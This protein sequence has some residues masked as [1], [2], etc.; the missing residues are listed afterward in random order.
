L[1]SWILILTII[2]SFCG[3]LANAQDHAIDDSKNPQYL[4][5]ITGDT[6]TFEGGKLTFKGV[7]IVTFYSMAAK[8]DV[9]HFLMGTFVEMWEKN[10]SAYKADPPDGTISVLDE[11][12]ALGAVIEVSNPVSTLNSITFKARVLEGKLPPAFNASSFFLKLNVIEAPHTQ[13]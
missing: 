1:K 3:V 11:K 9:G 10:S 13:N 4:F 5:I 2:F 6:G 7:P 8:R 12:G